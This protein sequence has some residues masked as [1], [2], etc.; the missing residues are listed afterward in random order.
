MSLF[1]TEDSESTEQIII[2]ANGYH[3]DLHVHCGYGEFSTS[4]KNSTIMALCGVS[5]MFLL[6]IY[7]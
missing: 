2:P 5:L 1:T 6:E 3:F 7:G 4:R